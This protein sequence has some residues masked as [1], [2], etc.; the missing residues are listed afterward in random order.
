MVAPTSFFSSYGGHI[1]IAEEADALKLLGHRVKVVT[2]HTGG[3]W[4]GLPIERTLRVPW[5]SDAE[6]GSSRHKVAFDALLGIKLMQVAL[7]ERPDIIHAHMHEGALVS[8][9]VHGLLRIPLVFDFQGS[10]TSEMVDHRFLN[11]RGVLYGPARRLETMINNAPNA[12]IAS[13]QRAVRLLREAYGCRAKSI[14]VV[15]DGVNPDFFSP[16]VIS[17]DERAALKARL[18]IPAHHKV[19]VYLGLLAPYQGTELLLQTAAEITRTRCDVHFLIMGYPG[20]DVYRARAQQL[21]VDRFCTFT[22]KIN[23]LDAPR[24]LALGDVAVAPKLSATEGL[25]K[26]LN[27]MSMALP[28][29]AFDTEVAREYLDAWG[30]YAEPGD[31]MQLARTLSALL[32]DGPRCIALGAALR[33]RVASHFTWQQAGQRIVDVYAQCLA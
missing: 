18:G 21:G 28:T 5:R 2:Y 9:P 6:V 12:L 19:V 22:G 23:Y 27:Y 25:G 20:V 31:V 4:N 26:V 24:H 16:G 33:E 10:L 32:D 3:A 11:P 29:V 17:A 14:T 15:P 1:R 8:L 30:V 7:S 13:S